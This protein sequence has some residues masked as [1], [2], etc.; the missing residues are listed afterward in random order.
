MIDAFISSPGDCGEERAALLWAVEVYNRVS[1][2]A[3]QTK[4][5][6]FG[7]AQLYAAHGAYAQQGV[8]RQLKKYDLHIGAGGIGATD[9]QRASRPC[10]IRR[11][12]TV[13]S[14]MV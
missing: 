12:V 7:P 1:I 6:A 8:N 9:N 10:Q 4:V 11:I 13:S 5:H 14:S 2:P 3:H